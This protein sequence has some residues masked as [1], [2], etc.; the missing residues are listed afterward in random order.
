MQR[1]SRWTNLIFLKWMEV[2]LLKN[3]IVSLNDSLSIPR[4]TS[5]FS[6]QNFQK[7]KL[8]I[9]C[10]RLNGLWSILKQLNRTGSLTLRA[11]K[12]TRVNP[13]FFYVRLRCREMR[14]PILQNK[15]SWWLRIREPSSL[16]L[17]D[18]AFS[19]V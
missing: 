4:K 5:Y 18:H 14:C 9:H 3:M 12:I 19:N 8:E 2:V 1:V 7:D 11:G 13:S 15:C 17:Q 6:Y 10:Q 16:Y